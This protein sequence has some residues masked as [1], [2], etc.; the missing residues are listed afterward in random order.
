MMDMSNHPKHSSNKQNKPGHSGFLIEP[1]LFQSFII[2]FKIPNLVHRPFCFLLFNNLMQ[3]TNLE[4][5]DID[6]HFSKVLL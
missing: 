2:V 3:M 6:L 4:Y 5:C 1:P